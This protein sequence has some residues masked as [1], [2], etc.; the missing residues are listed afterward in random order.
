M[1]STAPSLLFSIFMLLV[2]PGFLFTAVAGMVASWIDRKVTAR[3]QYRVGPPPLQPLYDFIKLLGKETIVPRGASRWVYLGAP[4]V[5]LSAVTLFSAMVGAAVFWPQYGF[6]GDLIVALYLLAI[7]SLALIAG[8]AASRNPI[9]SVGASREMK[10]MLGYELPILLAVGVV[11]VLTNGEIR[12]G[13]LVR[14]Q[15]EQAPTGPWVLATVLAMVAVIFGMQA[16]LGLVPF[17]AAESET[18]LMGGILVEYSGVPLAIYRLTR[19]M[20]LWSLP[21]FVVAVFWGADA[22]DIAGGFL[23]VAKYVALLVIITLMRNTNPRVRIQHA[24]GF[25]WKLA[26]LSALAGILVAFL[27]R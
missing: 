8:G 22:H 24:V 27:W 11:L 4:L 15:A 1:T 21:L 2:F 16:K 9:A 14:Q 20:L 18:E 6:T 26:G 25:L 13:E 10:M 7:P 17:D 19:T 23:T 12:L 5:G 3:V